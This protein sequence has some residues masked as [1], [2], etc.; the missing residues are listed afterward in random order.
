MIASLS[1]LPSFVLVLLF[2]AALGA[3]GW[4]LWS[5]MKRRTSESVPA[6]SEMESQPGG[7]YSTDSAPVA[8]PLDTGALVTQIQELFDSYRAAADEDLATRLQEFGRS[9]PK[10]PTGG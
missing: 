2:L 4:L 7:E 8:A 5:Q 6:P 1:G 3:F 10:G 9:L